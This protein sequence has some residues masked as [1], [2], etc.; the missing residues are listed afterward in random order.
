MENRIDLAIIG[1]GLFGTSALHFAHKLG[2]NAHIFE[3]SSH[4]GGKIISHQSPVPL[5][6]GPNTV[7]YTEGDFQQLIQEYNLDTSI[8]LGDA[9]SKKRLILHHNK[10]KALPTSPPSILFNKILTFREKLRFISALRSNPSEITNHTGLFEWIS[11]TFGPTV[12]HS[13]LDAFV[14]GIYATNSTELNFSATFPELAEALNSESSVLKGLQKFGSSRPK[15]IGIAALSGGWQQLPNCIGKRFSDYTHLNHAVKQVQQSSKG[16]KIECTNGSSFIAEKIL[17]GST[18]KS[19]HQIEHPFDFPDFTY[20]SL[21]LTHIQV[22]S[23]DAFPNAYGI[24]FPTVSQQTEYGILFNGKIFPEQHQNI[25]TVFS[26]LEESTDEIL[27]AVH[28]LFPKS[29]KLQV[30]HHKQWPQAIPK[31]TYDYLN[32]RAVFVYLRELSG[33]NAK[34]LSVAMSNIRKHYKDLVKNNENYHLS[35]GLF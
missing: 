21:A 12:G 32:K 6:L 5:E 30:L 2:M 26:P 27:Q 11:A 25:I 4:L 29:G 13:F 17:F 35:L 7:Q 15:V 19:M 34:Q 1:G 18:A 10:I 31:P 3:Q 24:L 9:S 8:I 28:R 23:I 14:K 22:D 33:L 16:W 20:T